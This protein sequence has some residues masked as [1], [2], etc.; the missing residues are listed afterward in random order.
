MPARIRSIKELLGDRFLP[1]HSDAAT[2]HFERLVDDFR[3]RDWEDATAKAGKFIEAVLKALWVHVGETV[4]A[5]R[6]FSAGNVM[7]RL[8]AKS[9]F[10]DTVRLTLP[11][12]CRF[13]YDIASNRG[14][15]HDA[16]EINANEMDASVVISTCAWILAELVRYS[17]R[18]LDL[19][20]AKAVVDGLMKK[21]FP[22]F[23]QIGDRVYTEAGRSALEVAL[24]LLAHVYPA[25]MSR[26]QLLSSIRRH[27]FSHGNAAVAVTRVLE[28]A[29]EDDVGNLL[30]LS[31]GLRKSEQI[32][33]DFAS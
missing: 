21:R 4:P 24:L 7:D 20:A 23:E 18:G 32:L 1:E 28:Y 13:V 29:D 17:Q 3:R 27:R 10:S 12:A 19:P 25:R 15:R 14:A 22:Y 5:G 26:P 2:D 8:P 33:A 9:A 11:R 16:A 31:R 30:L 6:D